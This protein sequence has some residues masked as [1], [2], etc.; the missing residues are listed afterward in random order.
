M[1]TRHARQRGVTLVELMIGIAVMGFLLSQAVPAFTIWMNNLRIRAAAE[2]ILN[3]LQLAKAE[4]VKSNLST[5]FVLTTASPAFGVTGSVSGTNWVVR[6]YQSG[7]T[8]T[9]ADFVQGRS[10]SDG[11]SNVS[12]AAGQAN[13]VFTP[14]G[15]LSNPPAADINID[16]TSS[17]AGSRSMRVSIS[18]GGQVLMCDPDV[19]AKGLNPN[20]PQ[21]C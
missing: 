7:G 6:T 8:Y 1:L 13:V 2:A 12:V 16:V 20:N 18:R 11:S 15:R 9:A 19:T 14:L 4:A 10:A 3:G 17:F 5:E 21:F